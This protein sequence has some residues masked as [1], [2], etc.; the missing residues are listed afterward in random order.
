MSSYTILIT[1]ILRSFANQK[2]TSSVLTYFQ[3]ATS[4]KDVSWVEANIKNMKVI[5]KQVFEYFLMPS[6][7]IT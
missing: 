2:R 3:L 7:I 1:P 6:Q 5:L 4:S